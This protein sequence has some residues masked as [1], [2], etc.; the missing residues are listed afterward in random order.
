[1]IEGWLLR[2]KELVASP[3]CDAREGAC[4]GA[5]WLLRNSMHLC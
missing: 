2:D 5:D 4:R 1:M 3:Q